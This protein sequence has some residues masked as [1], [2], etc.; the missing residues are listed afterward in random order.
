MQNIFTKTEG[1]VA[2]AIYGLLMITLALI[3]KGKRKQD[4]KEFLLAG[5]NVGLTFGAM[6]AAVSWV[7]A[8]AL[9]VG[10]QKAYSQG[11]AGLFSFTFPNFFA[12]ILFSFIA[13]KARKVFPEGFTLPQ[14]MRQR[15]GRRIQ[16]LYLFQ[17]LGLQTCSF[18]IQIFAGSTLISILCGL[19]PS[20]VALAIVFISLTY[21]LIGGLRAS[22]WTDVLQMT[23]IL[24]VIAFAVPMAVSEAGGLQMVFDGIGGK[25]GKGGFFLEPWILYS[26]GIPAAVTLLTGPVADQMQWQ[27]AFSI[28]SDKILIPTFFLGAC[29]FILVPLSLSLLGFLAANPTVSEGWQIIDPQMVGPS[30]IANLLP[31]VMLLAFS[32]MLLSGLC[33]TLDSI[34]CAVSSLASIDLVSDSEKLPQAKRILFARLGMLGVAFIGSML[35]FIP[36]VSIIYLWFFATSFRAPSFIPTVLTLFWKEMSPR[37]VGSAILFGFFTGAPVYLAG[38][39]NKNPHLIV[40]GSLLPLIVSGIVCVLGTSKSQ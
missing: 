30:V 16:L 28:K 38:A 8:P 34:L 11:I 23:L 33:S 17:F 5:R 1:L 31:Q 4:R 7:W 20:I 32:V 36:G 9:F 15:Y 10:S 39:L 21:S 37:V 35:T 13:L 12:L 18:A 22:I 29:L 27:R 26:F 2:L 3:A 25:D 19:D 24:T 6:S 14:L 40:A